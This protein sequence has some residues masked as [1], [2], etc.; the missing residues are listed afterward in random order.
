MPPGGVLCARDGRIAP[1]YPY[2]VQTWQLGNGPTM[3]FLGG[4]VVVD[5]ALRLKAELDD[6]STWVVAYA[7]DGMA[8]IPSERVLSEG[9]YEGASAM[10]Y[11]GRPSP[12]AAGLE[13]RIV[14]EVHRQHD[15]VG[16]EK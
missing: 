16:I 7:N 1:T 12:W 4:E 13:Q 8:Y 14:D 10:V 9:G 11:Y 2:P 6:R 3:V 15:L 5:Y